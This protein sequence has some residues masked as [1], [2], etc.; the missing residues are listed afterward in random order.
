MLQ[1]GEQNGESA[2]NPVN[3]EGAKG[4]MCKADS[5]SGE[6]MVRSTCSIL[7]QEGAQGGTVSVSMMKV[8]KLQA[9]ARPGRRDRGRALE[10]S[11]AR[12]TNVSGPPGASR[13]CS[14][15]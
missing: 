5:Y 12:E 2:K 11:K 13:A 14:L 6:E 7:H 1:I 10:T 8:P 9:V 4:Q 15:S 3:K